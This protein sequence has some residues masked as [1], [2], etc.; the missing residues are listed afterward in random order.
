MERVQESTDEF[1]E[2]REIIGRYDT[3]VATHMVMQFVFRKTL[4]IHIFLNI[5]LVIGLFFNYSVK[6]SFWW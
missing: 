2:I 6:K 5:Y 1:S 3:L 4:M